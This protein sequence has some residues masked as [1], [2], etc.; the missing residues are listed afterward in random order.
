MLVEQV[1][2]IDDVNHKFN[3]TATILQ[4][5][6]VLSK[7]DIDAMLKLAEIG[8]ALCIL[9]AMVSGVIIIPNPLGKLLTVG[10]ADKL[11]GTQFVVVEVQIL[12]TCEPAKEVFLETDKVP[13]VLYLVVNKVGVNCR[14]DKVFHHLEYALVE[15]FTVKNL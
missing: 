15:V 13:V 9:S 6:E 12:G 14:T 5:V 8:V 3:L 11:H 7:M 1:G 2:K 4:I 10:F